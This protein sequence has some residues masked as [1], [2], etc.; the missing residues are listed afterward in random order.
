MAVSQGVEFDDINRHP[1]RAVLISL[2]N[3]F[4]RLRCGFVIT[5]KSDISLILIQGDAHHGDENNEY[6]AARR[7]T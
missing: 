3:D 1:Q 4:I 6:I 5:E 7:Q 2:R